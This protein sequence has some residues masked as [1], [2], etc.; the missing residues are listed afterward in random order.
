MRLFRSHSENSSFLFAVQMDGASA[1][2]SVHAGGSSFRCT[3]WGV[4][5]LKNNSLLRNCS[6][7]CFDFG[8]SEEGQSML[9]KLRRRVH[10]MTS[11]V[12]AEMIL[13]QQR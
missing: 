7:Q 11:K 12:E 5:R 10:N 2:I 9:T 13:N 6:S 4:K 8:M 3:G 1:K